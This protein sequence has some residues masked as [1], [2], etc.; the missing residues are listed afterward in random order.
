MFHSLSSKRMI[1]T[2]VALVVGLGCATAPRQQP[3]K[4]GDINTD[5]GAVEAVQRQLEGTWDLV[6]L[7]VMPVRGAALAP[8]AAQGTLTY[9]KNGKLSIDA[10][11][12]DSYA[13]EAAQSGGVIAFEGKAVIDAAKSELQLTEMGDKVDPKAALSPER[14]RR[15]AFEGDLLRLSAMDSAG[16]VTTTS[17]W[18]RR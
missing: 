9:D 2:V 14:R 18:R 10:K 3:V 17:T 11:T 8:V 4:A 1:A 15:Y 5:P 7:A 16:R 13:P 12:S 6:T